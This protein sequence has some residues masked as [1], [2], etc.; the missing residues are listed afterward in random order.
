VESFGFLRWRR[1]RRD[2]VH[3]AEPRNNK[4][5]TT[6]RQRAVAVNPGTAPILFPAGLR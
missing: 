2:M 4:G 3:E 1:Q 6:T 5:V